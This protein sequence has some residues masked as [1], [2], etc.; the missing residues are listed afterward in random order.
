MKFVGS[1]ARLVKYILPLMHSYR[2]EGQ[3]WYEPFVGGGNMICCVGGDRIGSDVN[4]CLISCLSELSKGWVPNK[5]IS[6][7]FYSECRNKYNNLSYTEEEKHIIGYVGINGSYGGRYYDGGYAGITTTKQGKVRN[8]PEEAFNNVMKQ[9]KSLKGVEFNACNYT[10]SV[11]PDNSL[12]Y[13]DP[14]YADTKDYVEAN[15]SGYNTDNF[16]S[17]CRDKI[18]EGHTVFISEYKAPE[19]FVCVW[20]KGMKSSLSSNGV[21]GGSK[22]SVERLFL[23]KSQLQVK[24]SL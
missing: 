1:K 15:K 23:H 16:W 11:I 19:D 24:E 21:C 4:E 20:E 3:L 5:D 8:Y 14:P 2:K 9:A 17:W 10:D 12:I 22:D 13:C 7:D 6:R 18:E